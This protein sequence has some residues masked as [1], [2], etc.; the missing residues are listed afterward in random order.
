MHFAPDEEIKEASHQEAHSAS[1]VRMVEESS[2]EDDYV[3]DSTGGTE[4]TMETCKKKVD[5][6]IN[7]SSQHLML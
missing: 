6:F 2:D 4:H 7:K 3:P 1:S 5:K